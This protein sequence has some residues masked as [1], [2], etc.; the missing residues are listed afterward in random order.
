MD[1]GSIL[2]PGRE[3]ALWFGTAHWYRTDQNLSK[4]T[5]Q[6]IGIKSESKGLLWLALLQPDGDRA[7]LKFRQGI[8]EK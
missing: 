1:G 8:W 7:E 3:L 5:V 6:A 2:V 4:S